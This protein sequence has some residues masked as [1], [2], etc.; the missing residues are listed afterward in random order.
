MHGYRMAIGATIV[1]LVI[2]FGVYVVELGWGL[3]RGI[4]IG[5]S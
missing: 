3:G 1:A 4:G 2:A 5:R